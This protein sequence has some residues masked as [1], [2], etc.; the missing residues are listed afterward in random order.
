MTHNLPSFLLPVEYKIGNDIKTTQG[1]FFISSQSC[2][3][4]GESVF[5][6]HCD[7]LLAWSLVCFDDF[8]MTSLV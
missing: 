2:K 1:S 8:L 6:D 5:F 7:D 3:E 4:F